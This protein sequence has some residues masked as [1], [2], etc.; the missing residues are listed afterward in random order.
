MAS[1]VAELVERTPLSPRVVGLTFL[2]E[3]PPMWAAGQYMSLK[4]KDGATHAF[5]LASP[6]SE[7]APGRFEI[8]AVR[9]TTA[10]ALLALEVGSEVTVQGPSGSLVWQGEGPALLVATGTGISPLRAI[11]LDQLSRPQGAPL[12]LL[13]GCRDQV[14]ELWGA[15]FLALAAAHARFRFLPVHS[16]PAHGHAGLVGRV[17]A[18][19]PGLVRELGPGL[20]AYLC[21]HTPMVKDCTGLLVE[22]GV[23]V[24]HIHGESY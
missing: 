18:H 5:S 7:Q 15:E 10:E 24:E 4:L 21:G 6:R 13:F 8:A 20:H 14:E 23:P 12:R 11:L 1:F 22:H 3:T 17:Q 2:A 16:Q 9:G 19:L